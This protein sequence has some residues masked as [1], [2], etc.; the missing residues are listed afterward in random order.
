[1]EERALLLAPIS[2]GATTKSSGLN[3]PT[4][5]VQPF[6]GFVESGFPF[7]HNGGAA[8]TRQAAT[9]HN[10]LFAQQIHFEVDLFARPVVGMCTRYHKGP[11]SQ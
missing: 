3:A 5:A 8:P 2:K 7:T 9:G 11:I 6:L 4:T 1:M 10:A